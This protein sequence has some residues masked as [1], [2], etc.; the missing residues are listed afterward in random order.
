MRSLRIL[1]GFGASLLIPIK[2]TQKKSFVSSSRKKLP[3]CF[4]MRSLRILR[5]ASTRYSFSY[6]RRLHL[7]T[8]RISLRLAAFCARASSFSAFNFFNKVAKCNRF[9][10]EKE[11][12]V[13]AARKIRNER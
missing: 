1:R 10:Y 9:K 13:E 8:L 5:A 7:A 2:R 4:A 11:Y 3:D 6:L 12:R